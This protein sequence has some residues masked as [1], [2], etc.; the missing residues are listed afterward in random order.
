MRGLARATMQRSFLKAYGATLLLLGGIILGGAAGLLFG[1]AASAVKPVGD[2]AKTRKVEVCNE[3]FFRD[4]SNY[5][6]TWK[7]LVDGGILE[8]GTIDNL[9]VAPQTKKTYEIPFPIDEPDGFTTEVFLNIEFTLKEA[10][11]LL[12]KGHRVAFFQIPV[13]QN[14]DLLFNDFEDRDLYDFE[15]IFGMKTIGALSKSKI[16][17]DNKKK[18]DVITVWNN[19]FCIRFDKTTGLLKQY[20]A[21]GN[22]LLGEGGTLRQN[23]WRA[24]TDNDMGAKLHTFF[25]VWK[26]PKMTLT[27]LTS[28]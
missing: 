3:Y 25:K 12:E 27:E 19:N 7:M 23:F 22:D 13:M 8:E 11:P 24:P 2:I 15:E 1:P 10:E 17:I 28:S 6:M 14:K 18:S 5:Q 26:D 21:Y 20:Q 16:K 9:D 4:L